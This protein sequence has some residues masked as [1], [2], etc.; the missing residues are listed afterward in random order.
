M[1]QTRVLLADDHVLLMDAFRKLLEPEFEVVGTVSDGKSLIALATHLRPDLIVLDLGLPLLNGMDAGRKLKILLPKTRL[2]VVTMNEDVGVAV[3]ALREWASGFLLKKCAGTELV[4][5]I[6]ELMAGHS[7][8][9]PRVTQQ[10]EREFIRDPDA[11]CDKVLTR[12]QR[13]VLQLLAEGLTMKEAA[14]TLSLTARTVAFHKYS[15][16]QDFNLRSN[17]DLL[18]LAI[19]EQLVQTT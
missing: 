5:A 6:R 2:L 10:L 17:L 8:V 7:Y 12:R 11:Q 3:K 14:D 16:M 19:R 15:I 18:K 9:T 4:F 13:E 1:R